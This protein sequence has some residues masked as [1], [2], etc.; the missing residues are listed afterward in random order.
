MTRAGLTR[1]DGD[2]G[3]I[4]TLREIITFKKW[5]DNNVVSHAWIDKHAQRLS[6]LHWKG[7]ITHSFEEE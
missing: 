3:G 2:G 5:W 7:I 6:R 1:A 4:I